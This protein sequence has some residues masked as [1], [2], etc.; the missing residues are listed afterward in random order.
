MRTRCSAYFDK[1]DGR[2]LIYREPMPSVSPDDKRLDH[3]FVALES[4]AL[5]APRVAESMLDFMDVAQCVDNSEPLDFAQKCERGVGAAEKLMHELLQYDLLGRPGV[6]ML[7]PVSE[8]AGCY[9]A[10]STMDD[11]YW[12]IMCAT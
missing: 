1:G 5:A 4:W 9:A 12:M 7:K 3:M 2:K 10:K 11:A 6:G 8:R